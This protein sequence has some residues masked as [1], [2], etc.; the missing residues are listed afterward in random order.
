MTWSIVIATHTEERWDKVVEAVNLT[1][2]QSPPPNE[3][4]VVVDHNQALLDR[5]K[6]ELGHRVHAVANAEDRGPSGSRN[7]GALMATGTFI[8]YIDDDARP[9]PGWLN[10]LTEPFSDPSVI[11][12]AGLALPHWE[13]GDG[14]RWLPDEFLWVVGCHYR[15]HRTTAGPVRA[16]IGANMAFRRE[17]MIEHGGF[18][19]QVSRPPY[20]RC[21]ETELAIRLAARTG[22]H[23]E[24]QPSAVVLHSVPASRTRWRYFVR[25]CWLEGQAKADLAAHLGLAGATSVERQYA[26]RAL[27]SGFIR[28]LGA[29]LRR[30][31]WDIARAANIGVGFAVTAL[32]FLKGRLRRPAS[33]PDDFMTAPDHEMGPM[34]PSP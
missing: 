3:V 2:S 21:E 27:G 5:V 31:G 22:G 29:G 14:P 16:P 28:Y 30:P 20:A 24:F 34:R 4:I 15:G 26:L 6:D 1:L 17:Q 11:G 8:A 10:A 12:V 25:R 18:A 23:V 33:P 19:W 9:E 32:G 13:T 7:T